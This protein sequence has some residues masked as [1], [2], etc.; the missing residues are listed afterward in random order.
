MTSDFL[1]QRWKKVL[2]AIFIAFLFLITVVAY[3]INRYWSPILADQVRNTVLS[4]TDSLYQAEFTD[5]NLHIVQGKV[6]IHNFTIKP[7][8]Q[9]YRQKL[10]DGDAPNNLYTLKVKRIVFK[11]IHPLKLYY[12]HKLD[13]SQIVLSA[14]ELNITYRATQRKD[15]AAQYKRTAWQHI[16]GI[17]KYLHIGEIL[18]NDVKLTYRDNTIKQPF[19]SEFKEMNLLGKDL[20]IDSAS[21]QDS[22]RFYSFKDIQLEFNNFSRPVADSLYN[23]NIKLLKYSALARKLEAY[24]VAL[25]PTPDSLKLQQK[26]RTIFSVNAD[27]LLATG[28]DFNQYYRRHKFYVSRLALLSGNFSVTANPAIQPKKTDRVATFPNVAIRQLKNDFKLDTIQLHKINITYT[29][30]GK[31]SHKQGTVSFNKTSGYIFNVTNNPVALQKNNFASIRLQSWLMDAGNLQVD[32]KF[33]LTDS[34]HS[35][36]YKGSVGAMD[37]EKL[38]KAVMPFGLVKITSGNL[39]KLSFDINAD[40]TL[41]EGNVSFLYHDLKLHILKMDTIANRYQ[42]RAIASL[43]ANALI[44]KR[45]NPDRIGDAPRAIHVTYIRQPDTSFFKTIWKTLSKG[46]KASAGYD[47]VT[48]K[49]VK[50]HI[51]QHRLDKANRRIKKALRQQRRANRRRKSEL[52][53]Q[54]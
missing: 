14:P 36:H 4:S 24:H 19:V 37:L 52:E 21:Q 7:N 12:H 2:V 40:K 45:N 44:V 34:A 42:H 41:S 8:L 49:Q 53:K 27:T 6:V 46:I 33:N 17:L 31:R 39:D 9:V 29:G 20:L 16:K 26:K 28:L 11:H 5:A 48:E 54:R 43:L 35:Y 25:T 15:S 51:A 50:Q 47:E 30:Y 3:F 18:L 10:K 22:S 1:K 23:I 13:I 32:F 38:N